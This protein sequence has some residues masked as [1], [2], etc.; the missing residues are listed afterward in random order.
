MS[1]PPAWLEGVISTLQGDLPDWFRQFAPPPGVERE[2]AVLM[3]FGERPG[4]DGDEPTIEVVLTERGSALS[5]HAGQVSF[6]GGRLDPGEDA[7]TAALREAQ[8]EVGLDPGTVEVIGV[9]PPLYLSPSRNSVYPVIAWWCEPH[10]LHIASPFEVASIERV[11][12]ADIVDP[13]SRF[14][15]RV[16]DEYE[17]YGFDVHGLFVWG[18]TAHLLAIF[19]D[20]AG[21]T[22]PWDEEHVRSLPW[23]YLKPFVERRRDES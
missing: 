19:L 13:A 7:S 1:A 21:Q 3:L 2:S 12:V 10:D 17:G 23:K 5:S 11:A 14:T 20:A 16:G 22:V 9:L 15:V 6:P 18:F 4:S 8:E